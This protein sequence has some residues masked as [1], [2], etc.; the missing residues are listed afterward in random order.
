MKDTQTGREG[1]EGAK[2]SGV[3]R[4]AH[5]LALSR[6]EGLA[7]LLSLTTLPQHLDLCNMWTLATQA[8]HGRPTGSFE[9]ESLQMFGAVVGYLLEEIGSC[10]KALLVCIMR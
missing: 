9:T 8:A 5:V 1:M 2:D 10:L 4:T 7:G 6:R 3:C